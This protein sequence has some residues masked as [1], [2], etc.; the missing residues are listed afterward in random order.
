MAS[1][2]LARASGARVSVVVSFFIVLAHFVFA[3]AQ[4]SGRE[5]DCP[6]LMSNDS[7]CP[8]KAAGS[9]GL[10]GINVRGRVEFEARGI[11]ASALGELESRLCNQSCIETSNELK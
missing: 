2:S 6:T 1:S 4:L 7:N 11:V 8:A 5:L 3:Y 9:G 10:L